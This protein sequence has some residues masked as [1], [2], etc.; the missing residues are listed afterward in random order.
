VCRFYDARAAHDL[1][2]GVD[3]YAAVVIDYR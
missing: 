2:D 1:R 3:V